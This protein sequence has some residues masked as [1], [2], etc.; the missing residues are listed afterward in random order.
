MAKAIIA[1]TAK[2]YVLIKQDHCLYNQQWIVFYFNTE[3]SFTPK[4]K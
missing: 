4:L 2:R 3:G 1:D